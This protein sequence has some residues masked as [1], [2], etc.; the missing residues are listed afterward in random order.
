ML[1]K[2]KTLQTILGSDNFILTGSTALAFHGLANMGECNDLDLIIVNPSATALDVLTK[3]QLANPSKK[4][5]DTSPVNYSF[6]YEGVKVDIWVVQSFDDANPTFTKD[7]VQL[8]NIASIVK[9]KLSYGRP[10]DW[11]QLMKLSKKIY[12]ADLF[13]SKLETISCKDADDYEETA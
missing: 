1:Q 6:L 11:I 7:G 10:K 4:H 5:S 3:L 12:N 9:S 8:A 2:L 13:E